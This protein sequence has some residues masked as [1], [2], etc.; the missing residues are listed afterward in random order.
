MWTQGDSN[1]RPSYRKAGEIIAVLGSF[2]A[3]IELFRRD[4]KNLFPFYTQIFAY[5]RINLI[6]IFVER[7]VQWSGATKLDF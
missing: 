1:K 2:L 5:R 7:P 6:P 3:S 4:L